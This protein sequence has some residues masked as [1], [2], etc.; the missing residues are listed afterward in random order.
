MNIWGRIFTFNEAGE[1]FDLITRTQE[2]T[3]RCQIGSDC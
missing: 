1:V 3:L 2:G